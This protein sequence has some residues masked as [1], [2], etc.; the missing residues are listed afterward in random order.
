LKRGQTM[1]NRIKNGLSVCVVLGCGAYLAVKGYQAN[2]ANLK[3]AQINEA[4]A[5]SAANSTK[6][7]NLRSL[8]EGAMTEQKTK[9]ANL[10]AK[11]N[12][13]TASL[14]SAKRDRATTVASIKSMEKVFNALGFEA[15][16]EKKA[17]SAAP[18]AA[19]IVH[20]MPAFAEREAAAAPSAAPIAEATGLAPALV[21]QA[22]A[23]DG[24]LGS[25]ID[26][27]NG[28]AGKTMAEL[29]GPQQIKISGTSLI[30]TDHN[31]PRIGEKALRNL[32]PVLAKLRGWHV[33]Q[34]TM[35]VAAGTPESEV[36]LI[37]NF[38]QRQYGW[39]AE[40]L[41]NEDQ[42]ASMSPIEINVSGR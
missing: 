25:L 36:R 42:A 41:P 23:N 7:D 2:Q 37:K 29:Q 35:R 22:K 8:S 3:G 9:L 40:V 6:L 38:I 13:L 20:Q 30:L 33:G 15:T 1:N 19:K 4:S 5:A 27:A 32:S 11:V 12:E 28:N 18:A 39:K 17:V 16:A 31:R 14:E 26:R 24:S 10:E 21:S 34:V